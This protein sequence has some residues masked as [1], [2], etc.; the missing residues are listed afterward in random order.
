MA[1]QTLNSIALFLKNL[2]AHVVLGAVL[3]L[4]FILTV[5]ILG[6][7]KAS[8]LVSSPS[9]DVNQILEQTYV[10]SLSPMEQKVYKGL[11]VM[12]KS[13]WF[14]AWRGKNPLAVEKAMKRAADNIA[15]EASVIADSVSRDVTASTAANAAA[16]IIT[17]H[18]G[19]L[20]D[21]DKDILYRIKDAAMS[22]AST[23][24]ANSIGKPISEVMANVGK[25]LDAVLTLSKATPEQQK[26]LIA[27]K[28]ALVSSVSIIPVSMTPRQTAMVAANALAAPITMTNHNGSTMISITPIVNITPN[29]EVVVD[30]QSTRAQGV[31]KL[32]DALDAEI[33]TGKVN[34]KDVKLAASGDAAKLEILMKDFVDGKLANLRAASI[35][36]NLRLK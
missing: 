30:M 2:P 15:A 6:S 20:N 27:L 10:N 28:N 8:P 3:A 36:I 13:M 11:P 33:K 32:K 22:A 12:M 35:G 26:V 17:D 9:V 14:N 31:K 7:K 23:A 4:A 29:N 25:E 1:S 19:R 34:A 16:Q 21:A 5:I 24:A 18:A